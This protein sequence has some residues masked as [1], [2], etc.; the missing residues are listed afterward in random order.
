MEVSIGTDEIKVTEYVEEPEPIDDPTPVDPTPV[1]PDPPK[2]GCGA[3]AI[4]SILYFITI[5]GFAFI[6]RRR[7]N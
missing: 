3:G 4:Q 5:L 1:T 7:N 2:K 6:L